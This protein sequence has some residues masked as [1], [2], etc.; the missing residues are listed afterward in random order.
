MPLSLAG[1]WRWEAERREA[2][3]VRVSCPLPSLNWLNSP[4]APGAQSEASQQKKCSP[5]GT[6]TGGGCTRTYVT[7]SLWIDEQEPQGRGARE[8]GVDLALCCYCP[9]FWL[10]AS[11]FHPDRPSSPQAGRGHNLTCLSPQILL[12]PRLPSFC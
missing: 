1:V 6:V 9:V 4:T 7:R 3:A 11:H 8:G 2:D 12:S 5:A 10:S